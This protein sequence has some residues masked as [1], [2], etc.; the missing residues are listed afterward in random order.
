MT[1]IRH[2]TATLVVDGTSISGVITDA[3]G[4][5]QSFRGWLE[6]ISILQAQDAVTEQPPDPSP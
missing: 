2:L 6:L 3:G 5:Q 4:A 1:E